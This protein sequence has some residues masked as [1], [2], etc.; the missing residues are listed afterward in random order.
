MT[1][2]LDKDQQKIIKKKYIAFPEH[3]KV[4]V[5]EDGLVTILKF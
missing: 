4:L 1:K 3:T 5:K 2:K